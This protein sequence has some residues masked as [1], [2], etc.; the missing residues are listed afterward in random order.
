MNQ[1]VGCND[2]CP[3]GS[4]KKFKLCCG[5]RRGVNPTGPSRVSPGQVVTL[6]LAAGAILAGGMV[7][8]GPAPEEN[9]AVEE[10]EFVPNPYSQPEAWEYD[11]ANDRHWHEGHG[12]W[13]PG[14]PPPE[15]QRN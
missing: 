2:P 7:A 4:E 14:P 12:H 15:D 1:K 6:L 13:H 3:C 8:F 9:Q 10:T 5:V 11:A